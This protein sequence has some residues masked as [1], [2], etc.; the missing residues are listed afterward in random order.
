MNEL[1]ALMKKRMPLYSQADHVVDT[2]SGSVEEVAKQVALLA[3]G[4]DQTKD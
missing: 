2:T 4:L 3:E 1:K